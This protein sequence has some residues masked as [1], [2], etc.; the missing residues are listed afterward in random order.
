MQ[1][2][3]TILIIFFAGCS[4][5]GQGKDELIKS[6]YFG[7]GS[8]YV[9]PAQEKELGDWLDSIPNLLDK[10]EIEIISH[11][12]PIGGRRYNEWLSEMRSNTVLNI[13]TNRFIPENLIHIKDWSFENPVYNNQSFDG[14]IMNRRV[15][16][17]VRP[18]L[19]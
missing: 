1:R 2:L 4:V 9:D 6:I 18:I 12:D 10:Y 17:V 7:G 16:V 11:T 19:F 5:Y 3:S 8:Y 13:L 15:D 14:M